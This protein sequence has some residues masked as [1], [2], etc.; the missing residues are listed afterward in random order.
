MD[1]SRRSSAS[2]TLTAPRSLG[3]TDKTKRASRPWPSCWPN[4]AIGEQHK[5]KENIS[6]AGRDGREGWNDEEKEKDSRRKDPAPNTCIRPPS[7]FP[8]AVPV[9][10][11]FSH[12]RS[13]R[14]TGGYQVRS[15]AISHFP[16]RDFCMCSDSHTWPTV[17]SLSLSRSFGFFSSLGS[18]G[19]PSFIISHNGSIQ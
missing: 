18:S 10:I 8:F 19:D 14:F 11:C 13:D 2:S 4:R 7:M 16:D 6:A 1:P 5:Q 17:L 12:F 3:S 9:A 15:Y